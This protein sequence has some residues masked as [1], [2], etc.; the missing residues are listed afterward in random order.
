MIT[1][2]Q[3]LELAMDAYDKTWYDRAR[4]LQRFYSGDYDPDKELD[5]QPL[6][7]VSVSPGGGFWNE[8]PDSSAEKSAS[9]THDSAMIAS[10]V[11]VQGIVYTMPDF[12]IDI[13]APLSRA[14]NQAWLKKRWRMGRWP[15]KFLEMGMVGY[16]PTG[17]AFCEVGL[18]E[19]GDRRYADIVAISPLDV[20]WDA[21]NKN[22]NDWEWYLVRKRYSKA[23]FFK[24]WAKSLGTDV[25]KK[26]WDDYARSS[27]KSPAGGM[28][29]IGGNGALPGYSEPDAIYE[30]SFWSVDH[31]VIVLGDLEHGPIMGWNGQDWVKGTDSGEIGVHENPF[32]I[33]PIVAW[34]DNFSAT[35]KKPV[36]KGKSVFNIVSQSNKLENRMNEVVENTAPITAISTY[37]CQDKAFIAHIQG[38]GKM[39]E[40]GKPILTMH[41]DITKAISRIPGVEISET[42]LMALNRMDQHIAGATGTSDAERGLFM[43]RPGERVSAYEVKMQAQQGGIQRR[44][45][46][47]RFADFLATL[48]MTVRAIA[49][50]HDTFKDD[51]SFDG[52]QYAGDIINASEL[53]AIEALV[54]VSEDAIMELGTDAARQRAQEEF[55]TVF[56]PFLNAVNPETGGPLLSQKRVYQRLASSYGVA[57]PDSFFSEIAAQQPMAGPTGAGP[58]AVDPQ[59]AEMMHNT[60]GKDNAIK[61]N[62][63]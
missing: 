55:A 10:R 23:R 37:Q 22:P 13:D 2:S 29:T 31:H 60:P 15:G 25:V 52:V 19:L 18:S 38:G 51:I 53:L 5:E 49:S 6:G 26:V 47:S 46:A 61:P 35:S 8:Y 56:G 20:I 16:E 14:W 40:W 50:T 63:P 57:D 11:M 32:G 28:R 7:S 44:H 43:A 45:M 42:H 21:V 39:H 36:G 59:M 58:D 1:R 12:I 41:P 24:R 30:Y 34:W 62:V 9:G 33:I 17:V 48:A 27:K 4:R 54:S 3:I